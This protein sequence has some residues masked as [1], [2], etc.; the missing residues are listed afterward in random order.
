[1]NI[2]PKELYIQRMLV[3]LETEPQS[4]KYHQVMLNAEQF[5]KVSD[6]I[7][8]S[9]KPDAS[10]KPGYDMAEIEMSEEEYTLPDLQD[11]NP[12]H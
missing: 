1:M 12:H 7:I 10:L 4:N 8:V 11:I 6:A 3:F 9:T 5:K 2:D